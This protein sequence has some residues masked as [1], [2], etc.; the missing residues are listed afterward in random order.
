M[1]EVLNRAIARM[2]GAGTLCIAFIFWG[3]SLSYLEEIEKLNQYQPFDIQFWV[4]Y[5]NSF[6]NSCKL[7]EEWL[8]KHN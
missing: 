7:L 8:D 1:M 2:I 6:S 4:N 3:G 5:N